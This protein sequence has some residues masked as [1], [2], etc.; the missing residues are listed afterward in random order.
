M[1]A[2]ELLPL[3]LPFWPTFHVLLFDAIELKAL[4]RSSKN[5]SIALNT[6]TM[7]FALDPA[8]FVP[9]L[10]AALGFAPAVLLP[11]ASVLVV[12]LVVVVVVL[13]ALLS[14]V[15]GLAAALPLPVLALEEAVFADDRPS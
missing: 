1:L 2:F 11:D 12:V 13:V 4:N 14:V 9:L 10:L 15:L 3:P 6:S 7:G 8:L 5:V